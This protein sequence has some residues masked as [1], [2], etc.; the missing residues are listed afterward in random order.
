MRDI[1]D[2]NG[3]TLASPQTACYYVT[4]SSLQ[5]LVNRLDATI[6]YGS[7]E[8]RELPFYN[9]GAQNHTY[10]IENCP[11]WLT[12]SKYS[13]VMAPLALDYVTAT[14]SKDLNIGTYNEILYPTDEEGITEPF[15][16]NLTVE[17]EQPDWAKNVD[18]DLLQNTM[19]ISGQVFVYDE[20]DT[21]TRD[22]VGVFDDENRCHGFANISHDAVTGENGLFL[23]VYDDQASGRALNFSLSGSRIDYYLHINTF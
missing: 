4:N 8:S 23:T 15:Y 18:G 7:G 9:Y 2:K 5:W 22:I 14:A 20:L 10:K 1:E 6:K 17:G 11:K 19:S 16:L 13:D 21:D 12:L 3:N